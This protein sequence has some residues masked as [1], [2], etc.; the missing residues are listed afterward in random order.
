MVNNKKGKRMFL[1]ESAVN[2]MTDRLHEYFK[3]TVSV[4]RTRQYG[5]KQELESLIGEEAMILAK[6]VRNENKE[7]IPRISMSK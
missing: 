1:N 3:K 2:D 4:P 5:S 6:Y 7:W